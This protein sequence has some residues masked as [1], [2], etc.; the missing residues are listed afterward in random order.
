MK[1]KCNLPVVLPVVNASRLEVHDHPA[2]TVHFTLAQGKFDTVRSLFTD[3]EHAEFL[4]KLRETFEA[5]VQKTII[6]IMK[7]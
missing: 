7:R 3:E 2:I 4:R 6:E 1:T 5:Q